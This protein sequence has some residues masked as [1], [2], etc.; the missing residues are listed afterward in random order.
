MEAETCLEGI[1]VLGLSTAHYLKCEYS[2]GVCKELL[3]RFKI[4]SININLSAFVCVC[5]NVCINLLGE[6]I[7]AASNCGCSWG[8]TKGQGKREEI[9]TIH[10][11]DC[12]TVSVC[13]ISVCVYPH[14]YY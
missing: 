4:K 10:L 2:S 3:S 1:H 11:L 12:L 7:Q 13:I 6:D 9:F 8:G 5:V 14:I